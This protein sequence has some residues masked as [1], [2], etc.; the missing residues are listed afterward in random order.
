LIRTAYV[1]SINA[2]HTTAR[3]FARAISARHG[4][5]CVYL[6][7]LFD[8]S[9]LQPNDILLYV[10][11]APTWPLGLESVS[12]ITVAYFIDVHR[13]INSRLQI[14]SFFDLVFV[15]QKEYVKAFHQEGHSQT[16]WLPLACDE[17]I[18]NQST[19]ERSLD[20]G[21]VGKL[22]SR[23]TRR[24][25]ILSS[26]L[27]Q[28]RTNNYKRFFVPREMATVYG[29]SKIV[30]NVSINGDVNMRV[31]EGMAAGALLVTDRIG[32]GLNKLFT[33][34]V[35]YVGY[36][37]IDEAK[38]KISFYLAN[39]VEREQIAQA[40]QQEVLEH[41]TYLKRWETILQQTGTVKREAPAR[42]MSRRELGELYARVFVSLR[43]P[44]CIGAV[45]L[46]YGISIQIVRQWLV[47]WAR[48]LNARV[49]LTPNAIRARLER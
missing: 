21:F 48:W 32:N 45:C 13:E 38:E 35:H 14:A 12:C 2:E 23:G 3:Y 40:G 16:F 8:P 20:V 25:E 7:D 34:G 42:K 36:G 1:F 19:A 9:F 30:F 10:D 26:I 17:E 5:R 43:Q 6:D 15:A 27:P 29:Q 47:S 49:P 46:R 37:S 4:W 28:F 24:W 22:G 11:P 33:E 39:V 44:A 31:F 41:H 18:H